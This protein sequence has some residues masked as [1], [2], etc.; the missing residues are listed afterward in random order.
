MRVI[1]ATDGSELAVDAAERGLPLLV[2]TEVVV[3]AVA[4]A[5][6][7]D[8]AGGIGG[9]V[10]MQADAP[11]QRDA[12]HAAVDAARAVLP[13]DLRTGARSRVEAGDP[14]PMIVWVAEEESADMI[15]VGSHGKGALKRTFIGSVSDHVV[16]NAK[17]PVL[18]VRKR[19]EP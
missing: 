17:C 13:E 10:D 9:P 12:A 4:S 11:A 15:V 16:R 7:D 6:P 18:V 19:D 2:A 5:L 8:D 1:V 14:G 3:L